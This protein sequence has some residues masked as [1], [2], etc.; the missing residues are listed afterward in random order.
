MK[1]YMIEYYN[2]KKLERYLKFILFSTGLQEE[3]RLYMEY[4]GNGEKSDEMVIKK[5]QLYRADNLICEGFEV[6]YEIEKAVSDSAL[7]PEETVIYLYAFAKQHGLKKSDGSILF[8]ECITMN[9]EKAVTIGYGYKSSEAQSVAEFLRNDET[10]DEVICIDER[11]NWNI[12]IPIE[13]VDMTDEKKD[14][15]ETLIAF[16]A[17]NLTVNEQ[18][19]SSSLRVNLMEVLEEFKADFVK[20]S[21]KNQTTYAKELEEFIMELKKAMKE[22]DKKLCSLA[23][24]LLSE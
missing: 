6:I 8:A 23:Y 17:E 12:S 7:L 13:I 19:T 24:Q 1:D 11:W 3:Y 5:I 9:E 16:L 22:K 21:I 14:G 10:T 4:Y 20:S 2:A 15:Y 18:I